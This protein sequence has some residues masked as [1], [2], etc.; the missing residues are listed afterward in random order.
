MFPGAESPLGRRSALALVAAPAMTVLTSATTDAAPTSASASGRPRLAWVVG[1]SIAVLGRAALR[2]RLASSVGEVEI[3]AVSG[4]RVARL[5]ALVKKR[6]ARGDRPDVM[7]LALG[8]NP[9]PG[10]HRDDYERVVDT[11]PDGVAV[12]LVT[13]YRSDTSELPAVVPTMQHY[14]RA[15]RS[16]ACARANVC[17]APWRA[18]ASRRPGPLL[19]DGVHPTSRGSRVWARL[20]GDAV[21]RSWRSTQGSFS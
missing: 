18:A 7:V 15:M 8:T 2:Q 3:N 4:R 19:L 6:L 14:S 21:D 12:V 9:S 16:V 20:I 1:D 17:T 10:W 13:L 5:D 11:I